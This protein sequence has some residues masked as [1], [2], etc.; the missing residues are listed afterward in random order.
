M[1]E[2]AFPLQ[3]GCFHVIGDPDGF[4]TVVFSSLGGHWNWYLIPFNPLPFM[5]WLCFRH[6]AWHDRAFGY[7]T[8]ILL[9]SIP[10]MF[11]VTVQ[12]DLPHALI[13]ASL[14]VRTARKA[15]HQASLSQGKI[16]RRQNGHQFHRHV[17]H[18]E[19][20]RQI[21]DTETGQ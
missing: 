19:T 17:P 8:A 1:T 10:L 3:I 4:P 21:A 15:A 7:Y 20:H 9:I 16:D 5:L 2:H 14:A 11:A 13:V 6:Q 12:T 18:R